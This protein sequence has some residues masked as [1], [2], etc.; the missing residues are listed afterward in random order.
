MDGKAMYRG[1]YDTQPPELENIGFELTRI[2]L[3]GCPRKP[4]FKADGT[5][6]SSARGCDRSC[7]SRRRLWSGIAQTTPAQRRPIECPLIRCARD[8]M[9]YNLFGVDDWS[10]CQ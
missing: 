3:Q 9:S 1:R 2:S 8:R 6:I 10:S 7:S 4:L 5:E